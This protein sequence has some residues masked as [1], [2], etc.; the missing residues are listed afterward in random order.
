MTGPKKSQYISFRVTDEELHEIEEAALAA[1]AK[2]RDWCRQMV[3]EK[4]RREHGMTKSE[5][6]VY[7]ELSRV[8]YLIGHGFRLLAHDTLGP[9]EWENARATADHKAAQ[10][11]DQLL[12]ASR[13][14]ADAW[15]VGIHPRQGASEE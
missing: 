14:N 3:L 11:A 12:A 13:V 4:V 5:R 7:E 1:G 6:L 8:R 2:P 10:I 15:K 9:Q